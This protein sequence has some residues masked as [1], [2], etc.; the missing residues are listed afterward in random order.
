MSLKSLCLFV[1]AVLAAPMVARADAPSG[2]E[3][4]K[5]IE[6]FN[7]GKDQG[8][9]L[10]EL[11]PCL[12]VDS[13]KGSATIWDCTEPVAG[14]VKK[15]ATVHAWMNWLVPKDS[16]YDDLTIKWI[17]DGD[18]RNATD[19]SLTSAAIGARYFKSH[20]VDKV[21]KWEIKI[22]R[23]GKELGTAKFEVE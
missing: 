9:I 13:K 7:I 15:G 2:E 3:V 1:A 5:V 16:K 17:F 10:A 6:Y 8:P 19:L 21:G 23:G 12:T 4:K 11:K 18:T 14:K 20:T 22:V